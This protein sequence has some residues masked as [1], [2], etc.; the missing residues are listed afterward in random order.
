MKQVTLFIRLFFLL[1]LCHATLVAQQDRPI[2]TGQIRGAVVD[3]MGSFPL[4]F[5][6]LSFIDQATG[7]LTRG[8]ITDQNG[9]F[10]SEL[11]PAK[12]LLKIEYL[13]YRTK[14]V[15]PLT[16]NSDRSMIDLGQILLGPTAESL[17][18]VAV[19][20]EKSQYQLTLDKKVF[21]VGKDISSAGTDA[22]DV[23]ANVPS[24]LV[25]TEGNVSLR[26]S[27]S[28]RILIDGKPS[29]LSSSEGLQVLQANIIDRVEVITNPSARYD[30]EGLVGIINIVLKKSTRAGI[31]GSV[32]LS[33]GLPHN[34]KLA[35]NL[36]YRKDKVNYFVNL[37]VNYWER[38]GD[39]SY[40]NEFYL[41]NASYFTDLSHRRTRRSFSPFLNLGTDFH[42]DDKNV[43]TSSILFDYARQPHDAANFYR[44][45]DASGQWVGNEMRTDEEL[46]LSYALEYSLNY[47]RKC[48]QK[49]RKWSAVLQFTDNTQKEHSDFRE[50]QIDREM[51]P[52][53]DL[54]LE[55]RSNNNESDRNFLLQWDYT[56]PFG[57]DGKFESG[58]KMTSRRIRNRY[59]V[60]ER[61]LD[62]WF[63]LADFSDE[64][65]YRE[66]VYA[67]YGLLANKLGQWSYQ[68][69]LRG[70]WTKLKTELIETGR[71]N[72]RKPYFNFFP[73]FH[74][75]YQLKEGSS[76]QFSFSRRIQRPWFMF[77]NP[78]F[79]F[80]DDRNLGAGNPDLK[81]TYTNS[82]EVGHVI[83]WQNTSLSSG[84][85]YR[86]TADVI[87]FLTLVDEAGISSTFPDNFGAENAY[88]AELTFVQHFG[89]RWDL[90]LDL[91]F[92]RA[93]IE[94]G[95]ERPEYGND[96]YSWTGRLTNKIKLTKKH[97]LQLRLHYTAPQKTLQ[98]SAKSITYLDLTLRRKILKDKGQLTIA[99]RDVFNSRRWREIIQTQNFNSILETQYR[100]RTWIV[101]LNYRLG[102]D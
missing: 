100:K 14:I 29:S 69:G 73:S 59:V 1:V 96:Y 93:R 87:N 79:S 37:G 98:G 39:G 83:H 18:E 101:G 95:A 51:L 82:F 48:E 36:N 54:V 61:S 16:L 99:L 28:V 21:H 97:V 23:L 25:D 80:H 12:Y 63:A 94:G 65:D 35:T 42:I 76:V 30:A 78:F 10:A 2:N 91:N 40:D 27:T 22:I 50:W 46:E 90:D 74:L 38:P 70:E 56:T 88:G 49:G 7:N 67:A 85:Y 26:G 55:Q 8:T 41:E 68:I 4:E 17:T 86:R 13:S 81:P 11:R 71:V 102:H 52:T 58:F 15:G 32:D 34:H 5:A 77:L 3:S 53:N 31:N 9:E 43:L 47:D 44:D 57:E 6:T 45:Y 60:E 62:R 24:V 19:T 72:D 33:S 84:F 89:N 66:D 92:F 64:F 20:A 75:G